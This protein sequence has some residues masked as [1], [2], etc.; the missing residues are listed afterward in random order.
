M[1]WITFLIE[2]P[3][4]PHVEFWVYV[5]I[6]F[7]FAWLYSS[8]TAL[9]TLPLRTSSVFW[10][11]VGGADRSSFPNFLWTASHLLASAIN[12]ASG[13]CQY[14]QQKKWGRIRRPIFIFFGQLHKNVNISIK[15]SS[16]KGS[17]EKGK[18][19]FFNKNLVIPTY[20]SAKP[21]DSGLYRL[22]GM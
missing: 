8:S 11:G 17:A 18:L 4:N 7:W 15:M 14:Q 6:W 12:L 10:G 20:C 9:F 16:R 1:I 22:D 2:S 19:V 5:K 13:K 3:P 21:F